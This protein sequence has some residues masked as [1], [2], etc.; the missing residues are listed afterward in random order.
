MTPQTPSPGL[1]WRAYLVSALFIVAVGLPLLGFLAD[2]FPIS[3]FPMFASARP[4][5]VS[6]AHTVLIEAD[7]T[8]RLPS[9]SAVAND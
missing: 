2:G 7:G 9:P 1:R 3:T 6:I 8:Q 4:Q 5:E